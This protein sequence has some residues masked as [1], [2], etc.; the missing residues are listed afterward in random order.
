MKV[1]VVIS[2][3]Y[4]DQCIKGVTLDREIADALAKGLHDPR[5]EEVELVEDRAIIDQVKNFVPVW[6]VVF[7]ENGVVVDCVKTPQ[8]GEKIPCHVLQNS[9]KDNTFV[10]YSDEG[11]DVVMKIATDTRAQFLAKKFGI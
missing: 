6:H 10:V 7:Q 3:Y 1:Y 8:W 4:S 2:G 9:Y 11:K 5:I